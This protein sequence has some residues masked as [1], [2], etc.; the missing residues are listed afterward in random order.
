MLLNLVFCSVVE[1]I[2][3]SNCEWMTENYVAYCMKIMDKHP[4]D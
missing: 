2:E 3:K 1:N 4:I